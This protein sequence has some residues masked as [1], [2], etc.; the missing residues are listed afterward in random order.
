MAIE[1]VS[2]PIENGD[3]FH[4]YVELPEGIAPIRSL[5]VSFLTSRFSNGN[6]EDFEDSTHNHGDFKR[7]GLKPQGR[8]TPALKD[9]E[10]PTNYPRTQ[11]A[12]MVRLG[13]SL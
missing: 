12:N 3:F 10:T 8:T 5:I 4:S 7:R 6:S 11:S 13:T 2:F 9:V 1:I